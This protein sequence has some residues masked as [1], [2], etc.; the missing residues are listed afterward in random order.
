[1]HI[2]SLSSK[3]AVVVL[4]FYSRIGASLSAVHLFRAKERAS[5]AIDPLSS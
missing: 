5:A 3:Q 4:S 2:Y 1:M